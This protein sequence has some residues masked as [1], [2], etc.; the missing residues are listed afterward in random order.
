[1]NSFLNAIISLSP[2]LLVVMPVVGACIGWGVS[3]GG[4][5]FNRWTAFSNTLV[6]CLILVVVMFAPSLR[7]GSGESEERTTRLISVSLKLPSTTDSYAR[8]DADFEITHPRAIQMALDTTSVWFLLLPTCLWPFLILFSSRIATTSR[9]FYFLLLMLQALIAGMFVSHDL[10]SFITFLL[11]TTFCILCLIRIVSG[12]R[13]QIVFESTMYLQF[14]GD[15]LIIGGL[16][17]A[18]VAYSWMQSLLLEAPQAVTFQF[19]DLLQGTAS[20]IMR[21]SL[22]ATY[23]STVSPWIFLLLLAGF[24]IKGA[25]FPV[26][27][28]LTQWL[29]FTSLH[30]S[31]RPDMVGW[32]LLLLA[33]LTKISIYGMIRFMM[34]LNSEVGSSLYSLLTFWGMSGFLLTSLLASL[35]KDLLQ[36]VVWFLIGQT[37]LTLTVLFGAEPAMVPNFILLNVVQGLAC[38]LI[39]LIVPLITS[40]SGNGSGKLLLWICALSVLTLIGVPGLGGFTA[41]LTFLWSLANQN[42]LLATCYL[43]GTLLFN[44]ALIR[45]LWKLVNIDRRDLISIDRKTSSLPN[46]NVGLVWLS[47]SPAVLLIIVIGVSPATL[48]EKTLFPLNEMTA[49]SAEIPSEEN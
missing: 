23:W 2:V 28:G 16:L 26:H 7:K 43:T 6:S 8:T 14:L 4:L 32:Y 24:A 47:L 37:S 20:D 27:F 46:E 29:T 41:Q 11:L 17:L 39:L 15:A 45:S 5:E 36:I 33:L 38:C 48:L 42:M 9:L 13:S 40:E 30:R 19:H 31:S 3:R 44:L 10:I 22:A 21:Y 49:H 34:P 18:A 25:L 12:A 35:R 1:M